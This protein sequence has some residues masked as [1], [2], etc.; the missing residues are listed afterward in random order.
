MSAEVVGN[1]AEV[2]VVSEKILPHLVLG[3]CPE[4]ALLRNNRPFHEHVVRA[5]S[6]S[7]TTKFGVVKVIFGVV[8]AL[9]R[10][11]PIHVAIPTSVHLSRVLGVAREVEM[12]TAAPSANL[13]YL[14]I[15][16]F[17][18]GHGDS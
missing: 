5:F 13:I 12:R 17:G 1:S 10:G 8:G 9:I 6:G 18:F 4:R 16:C 7:P 11:M 14:E 15:V 2:S 3:K